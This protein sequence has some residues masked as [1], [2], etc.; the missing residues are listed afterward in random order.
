MVVL[1]HSAST[2]LKLELELESYSYRIPKE[3]S[4]S[5]NLTTPF[6]PVQRKLQISLQKS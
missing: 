5:L 4:S 2:P 6:G 3:P 1:N